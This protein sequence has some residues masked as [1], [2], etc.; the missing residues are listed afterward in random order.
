MVYQQELES[1]RSLIEDQQKIYQNKLKE[2]E[3]KYKTDYEL[4][5]NKYEN[6]TNQL[7]N[8]KVKEYSEKTIKDLIDLRKK[9]L[10]PTDSFKKDKLYSAFCTNWRDTK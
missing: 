10:N 6:Q 2:I 7:I 1:R 4:L 8:E 9:L 5:Q 3:N